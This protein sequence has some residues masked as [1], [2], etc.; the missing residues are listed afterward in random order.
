MGIG[1]VVIPPL[2]DTQKELL[3]TPVDSITEEMLFTP[4]PLVA[5]LAVS[6]VTTI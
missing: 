5:R 4:V 2:D 1:D 3:D 6:N